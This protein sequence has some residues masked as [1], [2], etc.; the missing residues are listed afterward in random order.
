MEQQL[1]MD[2]VD[3]LYVSVGLTQAHL[4]KCPPPKKAPPGLSTAE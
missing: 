4:N 3:I 1:H 2:A